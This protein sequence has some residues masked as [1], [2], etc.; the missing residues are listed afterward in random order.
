MHLHKS[1]PSQHPF[2]VVVGG[3]GG[4]GERGEGRSYL[5]FF[6]RQKERLAI[7]DIEGDFISGSFLLGGVK[8]ER[9]EEG[10]ERCGFIP[11]SLSLSSSERD[12]GSSSLFILLFISV[13]FERQIFNHDLKVVD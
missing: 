2:V 13:F 10:E 7:T 3:G 6:C 8:R 9:G 12:G 1:W 11:A 4:G 5:P